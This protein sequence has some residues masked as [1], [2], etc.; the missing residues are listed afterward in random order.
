MARV[1]SSD[2]NSSESDVDLAH[3]VKVKL[4]AD[5]LGGMQSGRTELRSHLD[6]SCFGEVTRRNV[7]RSTLGD[8]TREEVR[9]ALRDDVDRNV[10]TS[11]NHQTI[12]VRT[13]VV[14]DIKRAVPKGARV[15]HQRPVDQ[16]KISGEVR[17]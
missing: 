7:R 4:A 8:G 11:A 1:E 5:E 3:P 15:K 12:R 17:P 2:N 9:R 6:V 14:I 16:R 10:M 13:R